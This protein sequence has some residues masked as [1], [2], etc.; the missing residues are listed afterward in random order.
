LRHIYNSQ[1]GTSGYAPG[2]FLEMNSVISKKN[3]VDEM[4]DY[5][6]DLLD[7]DDNRSD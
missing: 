3:V 7:V 6:K 5:V 4:I 1:Q 2:H